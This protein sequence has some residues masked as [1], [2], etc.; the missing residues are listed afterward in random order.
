MAQHHFTE[1][2]ASRGVSTTPP[3]KCPICPHFSE[4]YA[5]LLRHYLTYHKQMDVLVAE[6]LGKPIAG[7][8]GCFPP[9]AEI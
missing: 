5:N 6:V 1:K 4:Q 9:I 3:H 8:V 2:L 7:G